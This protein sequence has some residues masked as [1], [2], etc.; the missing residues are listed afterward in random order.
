MEHKTAN[1]R[2]TSIAYRP[3]NSTID[4]E[5][6]CNILDEIYPEVNA[7]GNRIL[8]E[9]I[10]FVLAPDSIRHIL[11]SLVSTSVVR[12]G[13]IE[14]VILINNCSVPFIDPHLLRL[15]CLSVSIHFA[16]DF[17]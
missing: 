17:Q 8:A 10:R 7:I 12:D 2:P 13:S 6:H 3:G 14:M 15:R 5:I 4:H 9:I 1:F 16:F 11:N